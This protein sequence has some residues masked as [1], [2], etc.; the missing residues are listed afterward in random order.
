MS[1]GSRVRAWCW[2]GWFWRDVRVDLRDERG[3]TW[4]TDWNSLSVGIAYLQAHV[5]QGI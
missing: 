2:V 5:F 4:E 3:I 1:R